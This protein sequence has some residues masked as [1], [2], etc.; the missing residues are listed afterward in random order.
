MEYTYFS[1]SMGPLSPFVCCE[2]SLLIRSNAVW[3]NV[4]VVKSLCN[5]MDGIAL[6]EAVYAGKPNLCPE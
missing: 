3:N 1:M 6:A 5:S 4:M 2:V